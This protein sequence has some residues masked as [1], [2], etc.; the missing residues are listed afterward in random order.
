MSNEKLR[1]QR[2]AGIL[3]ESY[4]N[5]EVENN[6]QEN[7]SEEDDYDLIGSSDKSLSDFHV[8]DRIPYKNGYSVVNC[9]IMGWY[10][11][12]LVNDSTEKI[13]KEITHAR[14]YEIL[15]D[16]LKEKYNVGEGSKQKGPTDDEDDYYDEDDVRSPF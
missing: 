5:E 12:L 8:I 3:S 11:A 16:I 15:L 4:Y 7:Y 13:V 2:L 6:I 10:T 14:S 9:L 1:M